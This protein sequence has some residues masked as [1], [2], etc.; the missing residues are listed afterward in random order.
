MIWLGIAIATALLIIAIGV[1]ARRRVREDADAAN[2]DPLF[3]MGIAITGAGVALAA[4][5]GSVM[6]AVMAA[7]LI[8]MATGTYR[9]RH[10][11][12]G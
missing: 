1:L 8:V 7:G 6:Y 4:T 11:R 5:L 10:H 2:V 3:T 9:T 12:N